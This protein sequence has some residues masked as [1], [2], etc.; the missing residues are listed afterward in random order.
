L[1]I[2]DTVAA[3]RHGDRTIAVLTWLFF[4]SGAAGL[5][6]ESIWA[7]YLGLFVGH[8]AY[9]QITVLIIFLGGMSLGATAVS[10]FTTRLERH[11][12]PP[13]VHDAVAFYHGLAAWDF[14]EA[15]Q[16]AE[17]L[18][19]EFRRRK[20]WI[21][22]DDLRDGAV[23]ANLKLHDVPRA[24]RLF[25][26]LARISERPADGLQSRLIEMHLRRAGTGPD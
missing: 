13:P 8:D 16:A 5:I 26:L 2:A 4:L 15:A 20:F 6:Y 21:T 14:Q 18:L 22:P 17:R 1:T 19:P 9:G 24:R 23:I 11:H 7:R 25:R 3:K 12:A 10:G